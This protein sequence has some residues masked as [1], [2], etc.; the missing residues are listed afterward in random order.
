[1]IAIIQRVSA[2]SVIADGVPAGKIEQG[3]LV[4]LGVRRED[5]EREAEL[6]ARKTAALRVFCDENDKMN[7]ALT[8]VGGGALVVSNFTLCADTKKGNRPSFIDAM[9][10]EEADR[11]YKYFCECLRQNGV[12]R[13]ETGVFGADMQINMAADG[14]ITITLNTD[15]WS[16]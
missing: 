11:L 14:P 3:F 12:E 4:L 2:A 5:T 7:L 13:V 10:P 15:T 8:D 9:S 1:M 16:K 6:L